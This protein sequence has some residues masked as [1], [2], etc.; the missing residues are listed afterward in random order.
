M[1]AVERSDDMSGRIVLVTGAGRGIGAV[2]AALFARRGATVVVLDRD[3]TGAG[4]VAEEIAAAG[5]S[6][7]AEGVDVTDA[8][9]VKAAVARVAEAHG[10]P[11]DLVLNHTVH[12]CGSVVETSEAEWELSLAV[13]LTGSFHCLAAVLP[14]MIAEGRGSIVAISSDCAVRSCRDAAAYVATKAGLAALMR[15]VAVDHGPQ[16]IR[17]N[18]VTPGVTDTPLLRQAFSTGRD[19][20]ESLARAAGQS[21]LGRIGTAEEVA[22]MIAFVS[23]DRGS[24]VTGAELLVDGGMTVSYAGD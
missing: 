18:V 11:T 24:F 23:S 8:A 3:V 22:E 12:G 9:Q 20:D 7:R 4:R 10:A 17:A 6:A 2:T 13:N 1:Q 5:G 15:S 19:L 16:G 14:L 21:P